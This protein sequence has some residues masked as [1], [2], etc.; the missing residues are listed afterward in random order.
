MSNF[1]ARGL[2]SV[3]DEDLDIAVNRD[4]EGPRCLPRRIS[5][6]GLVRVRA[7]CWTSA[8]WSSTGST[9]GERQALGA[10]DKPAASDGARP[11]WR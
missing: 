11:D 3:D 10:S 6:A 5:L 2:E 7:K 8:S 4:P 1:A 9:G